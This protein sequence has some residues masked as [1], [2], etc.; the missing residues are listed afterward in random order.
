[1][2]N[3]SPLLTVVFF[4]LL[5]LASPLMATPATRDSDGSVF[6]RSLRSF[7]KVVQKWFGVVS[8][9]NGMIPPLP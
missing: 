3:R 1:M 4:L 8:N 2:R 9:D 5:S 7:A 6:T